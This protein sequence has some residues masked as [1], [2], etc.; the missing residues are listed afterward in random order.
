MLPLS[1]PFFPARFTRIRITKTMVK[2]RVESAYISGFIPFLISPYIRVER[3]FTPA[4][5]VNYV[6]TK[7]SMEMVKAMKNPERMPPASCG[8]T[9]LKNAYIP[10]APRSLA[11]S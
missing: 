11:A 1:S 2:I 9:T 8:S 6:T 7:S 10:F 3:V 5:F 4:P